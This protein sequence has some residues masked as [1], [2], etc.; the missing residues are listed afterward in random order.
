MLSPQ[1]IIVYH[2]YH[3]ETLSYLTFLKFVFMSR[4]KT[5]TTSVFAAMTNSASFESN[6]IIANRILKLFDI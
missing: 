6:I 1:N 3:T 2:L 4:P 5:D